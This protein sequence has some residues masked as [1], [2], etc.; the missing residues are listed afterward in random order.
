MLTLIPKY[1][2]KAL[3]KVLLIE[4]DLSSGRGGFLS[5]TKFCWFSVSSI[6]LL[7]LSIVYARVSYFPSL[8]QLVLAIA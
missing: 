4:Y 5:C 2:I 6:V 7:C 1:L 8:E 3:G